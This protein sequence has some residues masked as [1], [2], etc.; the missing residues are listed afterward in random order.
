MIIVSNTTPLRYLIEI[1][2]AGILRDLFS[3][4]V[5]PE[6]VHNELQ[7]PNTPRQVKD[8]IQVV[9]PWL[10][11]K[12]ADLSLFAPRI[13][14]HRGEREAIALAIEL[15]ADAILM[16]DRDAR[17]EAGR[18][19]LPIYPTL[20]ILELAAQKDFIDLPMAIA[21]LSQTSFRA[22]PALFQLLLERDRKRKEEK[23]RHD[24]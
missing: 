9:P 24:P 11:V 8:W 13:N 17:K 21:H 18:L 15:K 1:G 20:A 5:I 23:E 14:I 6:A 7:Q 22:K 16:D 2:H 19:L 4:V 3:S 10:E 12:K